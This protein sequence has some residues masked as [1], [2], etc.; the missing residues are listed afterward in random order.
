MSPVVIAIPSF[1]FTSPFSLIVY[2]YPSFFTVHGNSSFSD[3]VISIPL[4]VSSCSNMSLSITSPS[5][6]F[7]ACTAK[8]ICSSTVFC[9]F[10][11]FAFCALVSIPLSPVNVAIVT[12]ASI[13]RTMIVITSA[14]SVIPFLLFT[15]SFKFCFI[16]SFLLL[17][18]IFYMHFKF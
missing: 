9:A 15:L 8:F 17:C 1:S 18:Y 10:F 2:T 12:P 16:C 6:I 11:S 3:F 14:I 13:R 7:D 5:F 4:F